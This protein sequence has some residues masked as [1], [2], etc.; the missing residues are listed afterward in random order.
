MKRAIY[1][2]LIVVACRAIFPAT[3]WGRVTI[4]IE[5]GAPEKAVPEKAADDPEKNDGADVPAPPA[6]EDGAHPGEPILHKGQPEA[7]VAPGRPEE[8]PEGL[9]AEEAQRRLDEVRQT[10][11]AIDARIVAIQN[12]KGE[13]GDELNRLLEQRAKFAKAEERLRDWMRREEQANPRSVAKDGGDPASK[14][15]ADGAPIGSGAK[16]FPPAQNPFPSLPATNEL[17]TDPAELAEQIRQIDDVIRRREQNGGPQPG[18]AGYDDGYLAS[19]RARATQQ[20]AAL[21]ALQGMLIAN[22]I[23][24]AAKAGETVTTVGPR[25][26]RTGYDPAD[27]VPKSLQAPTVVHPGQFEYTVMPDGS[28]TTIRSG[29]QSYYY[30]SGRPG[31]PL[32]FYAPTGNRLYVFD[33]QTR[34]ISPSSYLIPAGITLPYRR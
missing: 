14:N 16:Q 8:L 30:F 31:E 20:V 1:L 22:G 26:A 28:R 32:L 5:K 24:D 17:S 25:L 29:S 27:F 2:V 23:Q 19:L 10:L 18:P 33:P 34:R 11:A 15:K 12:G 7:R 21:A 9:T 6:D 4:G 3:A 13:G